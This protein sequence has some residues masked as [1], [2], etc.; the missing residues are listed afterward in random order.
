MNNEEAS[1][2]YENE[3]DVMKVIKKVAGVWG[4]ILINVS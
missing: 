3:I 1:R 2:Q 4:N